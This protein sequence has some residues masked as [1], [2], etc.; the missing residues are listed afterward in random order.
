MSLT[1]IVAN[2]LIKGSTR[3]DWIDGFLG[4]ATALMYLSGSEELQTI[5]Y[6]LSVAELAILKAPFVLKYIAKSNDYL[7]LVYWIPKEIFANMN[8]VGGFLDIIPTYISRVA[9]FVD[10]NKK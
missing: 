8:P 3:I 2:N 4:P 7:S 10:K 1:K 5:G 9:Y 6:I